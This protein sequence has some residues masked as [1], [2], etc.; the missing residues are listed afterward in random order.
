MPD[1][2]ATN[3]APL[4]FIDLQAQRRRIGPRMEEA[5][6]KVLAHGRYIMGPEVAEF[7]RRLA[8]FCGARHVLS[9]ANGTDALG[10]A[11]MAKRVR[12]GDAVLVPSFTFAATAEVVAWFGASPVFVDVFEDS[13]NMDPASL[14]AGIAAAKRAGLVPVGVIPVDLF[15]LP[16]GYDEIL[17]IAAAHRLWVVA[18]AAQSFGASYKGRNVGT[19]GDIAT[20]SFFPAK[21]LGCYGDGGAV[22]L[23]DDETF[24]VLKSLRVHGQGTDKYDNVRIGLNARLDTIQAAVLIE[25]LAIFAEEVAARDRVAARYDELLGDMVATPRIPPGMTSVWAQYTVRLPA[26]HD[27]DRVAARLKEEG[28]PTAVYYAKPLHRQTAYRDYPVAGNGLPVSDRLADSVLSLPMHPY[29]DE[30]TQDRIAAALEAA[31]D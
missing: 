9:C 13:F 23:E 8:Q 11:L 14:E 16:A 22:F 31:L 21:P 20:T 29:L 17:E 25:K 6:R 26:G 7:E 10:L 24:E 30:A 18:D 1:T 3:A 27:R 28:I 2:V 5:I 15:G 19:I 4:E 12:P